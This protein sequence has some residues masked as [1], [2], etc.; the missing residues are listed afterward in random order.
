MWADVLTKLL[1]GKAFRLMR[2]KLMNFSV[3]YED[4]E[5]SEEKSP[6]MSVANDG[7]ARSNKPKPVTGRVSCRAPTQAL[8]ECVGRPRLSVATDRRL[9]RVSRIQ[10]RVRRMGLTRV[11]QNTNEEGRRILQRDA[12]NK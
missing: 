3:D 8:Q 1:Q 10:D 7:K 5:V 12:S 6:K 4:Q 9:V 11:Q 2:S